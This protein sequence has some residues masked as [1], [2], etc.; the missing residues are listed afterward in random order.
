[1]WP[2]IRYNPYPAPNAA[3][4]FDNASVATSMSVGFLGSDHVEPLELSFIISTKLRFFVSDF[5]IFK[6]SKWA[7]SFA[8]SPCRAVHYG[9]GIGSP[10]LEFLQ[11]KQTCTNSITSALMPLHPWQIWRQLFVLLCPRGPP[12]PQCA[13][14]NIS[15]F[16]SFC[17]EGIQIFTSNLLILPAYVVTAIPAAWF[18]CI[19]LP[20]RSLSS[21]FFLRFYQ[22]TTCC[23]YISSCHF[24]DSIPLCPSR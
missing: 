22:T 6:M 5:L 24:L 4:H 13:F 16:V 8:C 23:D 14:K 21:A 7:T 10:V 12:N 19:S 20:H 2:T 3:I 9:G 11:C 17:L 18:L 1:M 15:S